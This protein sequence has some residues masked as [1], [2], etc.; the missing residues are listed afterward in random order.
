MKIRF[1]K[2]VSGSAIMSLA[3][4]GIAFDSFVEI[5]QESGFLVAFKFIGIT[6]FAVTLLLTMFFGGLFIV[7]S[8]VESEASDNE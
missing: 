4:C 5:M 3:L 2:I 8:A 7:V 1:R 6:F